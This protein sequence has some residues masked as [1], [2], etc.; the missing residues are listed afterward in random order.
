MIPSAPYLF[1][2]RDPPLQLCNHLYCLVTISPHCG[3]HTLIDIDDK[4][5]GIILDAPG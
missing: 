4:S 5:G 2:I 3:C 1:K